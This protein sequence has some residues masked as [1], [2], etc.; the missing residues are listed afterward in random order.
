MANVNKY[1]KVM[2]GNKEPYIKNL[3]N[4]KVINI[5]GKS[6]SGKSSFSDK[7]IKDGNYF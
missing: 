5:T 1:V 2:F 7:Y 3:T 6:S 4:D